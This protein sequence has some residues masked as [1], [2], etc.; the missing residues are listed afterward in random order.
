[1]HIVVVGGKARSIVRHRGSLV[2]SLIKDG[3]SVLC[4]APDDE[5][6]M[7]EKIPSDLGARFEGV[8]IRRLKR[9]P[10][11]E[12]VAVYAMFQII[13][14]EKPDLVFNYTVK[15]VIWGSIAAKLAGAK[16]IVSLITG[17]GQAFVTLT[18][19]E[20]VLNRIV[21]FLYR[22]AL[23]CNQSVIFQNA[24]DAQLFLELGILESL[25]KVRVVNGSGI[26]MTQFER[27][28]LPNTAPQF[29]WLGRLL[30]D[31]GLLELVEAM[32]RIKQ[33]HPDS[34]PLRVLGLFDHDHPASLSRRQ[35]DSWHEEGLIDFLGG[36]DDVRPFIADASVICLP[37]YREGTP[38]SVLEAMAIGRPII[39]TDVPGCRQTVVHGHNGFLVKAADVNTL[40]SV[41]LQIL[42][43]PE[44]IP[45]MAENSYRFCIDKYKVEDVN[46]SMTKIMV[47]GSA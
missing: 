10:L 33:K 24:D 35:V 27:K 45:V 31:K 11:Q 36:T 44:L 40:E 34:R 7:A 13:R 19:K 18:L 3:H 12:L 46:R 43:N 2:R 37:S 30:K 41:M 29:L 9:N 23:R 4:L 39:T 42:E 14:R 5:L 38:R 21:V 25:A 1:M 22:I 15:P 26:D 17:L 47:P 28:P 32:R 16:G 20:K 8:P 6:H